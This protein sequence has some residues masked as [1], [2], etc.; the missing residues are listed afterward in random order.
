MSEELTYS[1]VAPDE[2]P[3]LWEIIS[4]SLHRSMQPGWNERT[5]YVKM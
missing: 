4:Q 5:S 1:T 3:Q 2:A